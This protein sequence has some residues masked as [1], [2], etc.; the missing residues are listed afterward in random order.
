MTKTLRRIAI[1]AAAA[2][3]A[4][5]VGMKPL[6]AIGTDEPPPPADSGSKKSD[7]RRRQEEERH[8]GRQEE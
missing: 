3:L 7:T 1:L 2:L 8:Q 5:A 4:T 6:Y